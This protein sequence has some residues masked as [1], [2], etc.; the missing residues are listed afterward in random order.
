M[1]EDEILK[2]ITLAAAIPLARAAL[3]L[4]CETVFTVNGGCP[5]CGS[6]HFVPLARWIAS[7]D[8]G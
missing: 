3:C 6:N 8:H 4:D 1:N 7:A 2:T 5:S